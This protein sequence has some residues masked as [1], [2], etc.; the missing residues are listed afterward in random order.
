MKIICT[1][2][3]CLMSFALFAQQPFATITLNNGEAITA[4]DGGG[5]K[6][7]LLKIRKQGRAIANSNLSYITLDGE[8]LI[9][10]SKSGEI[11]KLDVDA[12]KMVTISV[13]ENPTI[14]MTIKETSLSTDF[15]RANL[16]TDIILVPL[17]I[18]KKRHHLVQVIATNDKYI[19][20]NYFA[21]GINYF[22]I[23]DKEYNL[24]EK[25]I[26][27]SLTRKK[28]EKAIEEVKNYFGNCNN[29]I[30]ALEENVKNTFGKG[31][32]KQY[33]LLMTINEDVEPRTGTNVINNLSCN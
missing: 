12:I 1:Y 2:F 32:Q 21:N 27:H 6:D 28:S 18:Y 19:L 13:K 22:Y 5:N 3:L 20:T 11:E 4:Y 7:A 14:Q 30:S 24:I 9:Y 8:T 26:M 31:I 15:V 17:E 25:R 29:L 10:Y 16:T 23:C 33:F